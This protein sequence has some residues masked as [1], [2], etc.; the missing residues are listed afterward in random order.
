[1]T[2][3]SLTYYVTRHGNN[4]EGVVKARQVAEGAKESEIQLDQSNPIH[5]FVKMQ[6]GFRP[7][8]SYKTNVENV[9]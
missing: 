5:I 8:L 3:D 2:V 9:W 4:Q 7:V 1:M 6:A